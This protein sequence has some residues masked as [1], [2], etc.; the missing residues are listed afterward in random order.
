M[1]IIATAIVLAGALTA[2]SDPRNTL[3]PQD[4]SKLATM[5]P[6]LEKLSVEDRQLL[7]GYIVRETIGA[8]FGGILG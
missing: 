8:K 4:V 7:S 2:C 3:L 5:Q 1:R 6:T